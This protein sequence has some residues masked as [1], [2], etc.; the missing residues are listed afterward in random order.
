MLLCSGEAVRYKILSTEIVSFLFVVVALSMALTPFLAE[1]GQRLGKTFERGDMKVTSH[2]AHALKQF[3]AWSRLLSFNCP[4]LP[5][6]QKAL[7]RSVMNKHVVI[8]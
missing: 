3:P 1:F 5:N 7:R 8:N 2:D 4:Q 6:Q